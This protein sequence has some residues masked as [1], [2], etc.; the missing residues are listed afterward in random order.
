MSQPWG[1]TGPQFLV[2]YSVGI[3]VVLVVPYLLRLLVRFG[4]SA[5]ADGQLD[6]YGSATWQA[7]R[8]ARHR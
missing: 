7:V 3:A 1:L 8:P 4:S 5:D 6:P 2:I